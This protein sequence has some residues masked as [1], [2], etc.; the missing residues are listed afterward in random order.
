MK[1]DVKTEL[2][3][4]MKVRMF[5]LGM[6]ERTLAK[7]TGVSDRSISNYVTRKNTMKADALVAIAEGLEC[8]ADWLLGLENKKEKV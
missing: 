8:S 5:E 2:S 6:T 4:R 7:K 1:K 3:R